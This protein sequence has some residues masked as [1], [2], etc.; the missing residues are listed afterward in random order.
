MILTAGPAELAFHSARVALG[1]EHLLN[2]PGLALAG[3]RVQDSTLIVEALK[4]APK[5][6]CIGGRA[7]DSVLDFLVSPIE[8]GSE[9]A[10]R[11][12]IARHNRG[13][14]HPPFVPPDA[15]DDA[16]LLVVAFENLLRVTGTCWRE[17]SRDYWIDGPLSWSADG[18]SSD[19]ADE[20][21]IPR[22]LRDGAWSVVLVGYQVGNEVRAPFVPMGWEAA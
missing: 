10:R 18:A 15:P 7:T 3:Q 19:W 1:G 8:P 9:T 21:G 4:A 6:V 17:F 2:N 16:V 20:M 22:S 11:F 5:P 12:Q 14:D 13:G